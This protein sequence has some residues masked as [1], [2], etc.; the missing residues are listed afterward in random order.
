MESSGHNSNPINVDNEM[1]DVEDKIQESQSVELVKKRKTGQR[2]M[3]VAFGG[4]FGQI[5][6]VVCHSYIV[7]ATINAS[8][9]L[10]QYIILTITKNT[11]LQNHDNAT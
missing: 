3:V 1:E 9:I 11:R 2:A 4:G 6:L 7:H 10:Q 5:L 8:Y